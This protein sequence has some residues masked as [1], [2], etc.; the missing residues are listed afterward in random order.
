MPKP[1]HWI[2]LVFLVGCYGSA[3]LFIKPALTAT[4]PAPVVLGRLPTGF[5]L[6]LPV[7]L[8]MR[9]KLPLTR[10]ALTDMAGIAIIGFALPFGLVAWGQQMVPSSMAGIMMSL[11]PI[12]TIGLAHLFLPEEPLTRRKSAG[13]LLALLGTLALIGPSAA[14]GFG[15]DPAMLIRELAILGAAT[16]YGVTAVLTKRAAPVHPIMAS[17]VV[18]FIAALATAPFALPGAV[19]EINAAPWPA[20]AAMLMLGVLP[21]AA[22]T[23]VLFMLIRETGASFFALGN[24]MTPFWAAFLGASLGMERI[25]WNALAG[26]ILVLG[27]V[28]IAQGKLNTL[29]RPS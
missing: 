16:S 14:A 4:A 12:M 26:L 1:R 2:F 9:L 3:F 21:T 29:G 22:A 17:T 15:G 20:I 8:F 27:G 23:I 28:A 13:F 18:L 19:D 24:Y 10:R 11:M 7:A 6:L 5:L 25:E